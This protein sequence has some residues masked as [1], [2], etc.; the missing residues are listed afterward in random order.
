MAKSPKYADED[1]NE[2]EDAA[3]SIPIIN[4]LLAFLP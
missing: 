4:E 3:T 2:P 1:S